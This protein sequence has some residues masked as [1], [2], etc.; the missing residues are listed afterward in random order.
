MTTKKC[1]QNLGT[2][3]ENKNQLWSWKISNLIQLLDSEI[4]HYSQRFFADFL[5]FFFEKTTFEEFVEICE[6]IHMSDFLEMI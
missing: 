4:S 3:W 1:K 2:G 5:E 6:H